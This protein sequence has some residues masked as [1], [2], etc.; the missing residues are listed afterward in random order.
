MLRR[1][2][3]E[4]IRQLRK[5]AGLTQAELAERADMDYKYLGGVERGER[6]IT[7]DNV[8]RI[9]KGFGIEPYQLFLFSLA[10]QKPGEVV[11]EEKLGD[12]VKHCSPR[13]KELMLRVIAEIARWE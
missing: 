4:R 3:G 11:T 2:L 9:A 6:N 12:I 13:K 8:E 1:E 7:I 10:A 5:A